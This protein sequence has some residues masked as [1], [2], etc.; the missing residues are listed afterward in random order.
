MNELVFTVEAD[1][2][3]G[4]VAH[5][6]LEKGSIVTQGDTLPELKAMI[7]DAIDGFFFDKPDQKPQVVRLQFEEVFSLAAA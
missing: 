6:R 5:A 7:V 3:G 1:E 2:D 4:Y